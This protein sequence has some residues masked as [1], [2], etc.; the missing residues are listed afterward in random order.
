MAVSV[1]SRL[2]CS[3]ERERERPGRVRDDGRGLQSAP[4]FLSQSGL[5][6]AVLAFGVWVED[7][8]FQAV[9]VGLGIRVQDEGCGV[10]SFEFRVY[11]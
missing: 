6:F 7:S 1:N 8:G 5:G 2:A 10:S 11:C 4:P 9:V 3:G